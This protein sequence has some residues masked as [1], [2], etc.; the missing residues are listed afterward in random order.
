MSPFTT[1]TTRE[2]DYDCRLVKGVFTTQ[3]TTKENE[4]NDIEVTIRRN[5][6][7]KGV[8]SA[9][10]VSMTGYILY[11]ATSTTL[12]HFAPSLLASTIVNP[13]LRVGTFCT[14]CRGFAMASLATPTHEVP[15]GRGK[16]W[17]TSATPAVCWSWN[18]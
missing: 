11:Q 2:A 10:P 6:D 1:V 12:E 7:G 17:W 4:E 9:C 8:K 14:L 3:F 13:R 5:Y 16:I 15:Q 18:S